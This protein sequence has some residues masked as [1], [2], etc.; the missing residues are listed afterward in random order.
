[1]APLGRPCDFLDVEYQS[2]RGA[3]WDRRLPAQGRQQAVL[4]LPGLQ[5]AQSERDPFRAP[6]GVG[7]CHQ[8]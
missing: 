3:S 7:A 4:V 8:P 6:Y 5:V 2:C 1:M